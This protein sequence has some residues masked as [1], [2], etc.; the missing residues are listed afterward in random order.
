MST[1]VVGRKRGDVLALFQGSSG[2]L[3]QLLLC[4]K[5]IFLQLPRSR[6]LEVD[7]SPGKEK[8][9]VLTSPVPA[10]ELTKAQTVKLDAL[11]Q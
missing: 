4:T 2:G 5:V 1:E 9:L 11:Q 7:L 10:V 6:L 3:G 8:A